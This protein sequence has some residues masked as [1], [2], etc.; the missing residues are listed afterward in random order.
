MESYILGD[1][2]PEYHTSTQWK[3][4]LYAEDQVTPAVNK[5]NFMNTVTDRYR[6]KGLLFT[7]LESVSFILLGIS[8]THCIIWRFVQPM[9]IITPYNTECHN[10]YYVERN[11]SWLFDKTENLFRWYKNKYV[12]LLIFKNGNWK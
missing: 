10:N 6:N 8:D 5:I 12:M 9:N 1:W 11:S 4:N 7:G 2:I 3:I